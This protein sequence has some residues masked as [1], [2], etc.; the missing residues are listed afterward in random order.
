MPGEHQVVGLCGGF[1][2]DLGECA[3]VRADDFLDVLPVVFRMGPGEAEGDIGVALAVD[4]RDAEGVADDAGAVGV[5]SGGRRGGAAGEGD[6]GYGECERAEHGAVSLF[7][8][9]VVGGE[10]RG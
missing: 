6:G 8:A 10:A 9:K 1:A 2:I 4:V 3:A 7:W 5:C